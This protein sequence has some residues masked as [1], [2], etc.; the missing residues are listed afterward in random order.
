MSDEQKTYDPVGRRSH[1]VG[2]QG[3]LDKFHAEMPEGT[4]ALN[5]GCG[6]QR[7]DGFVN[8]DFMPDDAVDVV[9]NLFEP[10]WPFAD[11]SVGFVYMNNFLEHVPGTA[12]ATLWSELWRVSAEGARIMVISPHARS[13]RYLQDPTH[14]QPIID[15]KFMYL[16]K[17]WRVGNKLNH[18]YYCHPD[19]NFLMDIRPWKLWHNDVSM[20]EDSAKLW[21]ELH[22]TNAIEDQI[23]F[24]KAF[25]TPEA[26]ESYKR[27]IEARMNGQ[28][29]QG[30]S[31]EV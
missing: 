24:L 12:W 20:R 6:Q 2:I 31:I 15:R 10:N 1:T 4:V 11:Q 16:S 27:I 22:D 21:A 17:E 5:V 25:R 23:W 8:V 3:A 14:C 19:V 29:E 30:Q 18:G 26:L 13:D 7:M 9:C 28:D